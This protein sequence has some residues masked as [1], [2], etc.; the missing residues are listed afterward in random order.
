MKV[1]FNIT[2]GLLFILAGGL[3][4]SSYII[5]Y[6][7]ELNIHTNSMPQ[8]VTTRQAEQPTEDQA[9]AYPTNVSI[10]SVNLSVAVDPG[11]YDAASQT[12]TLS[13]TAAFF[14]TISTPPN[15]VSGD[16]YIYGH[17]RGN[18][19]NPLNN[20]AIGTTA[21]VETA[22]NKTYT[23]KLSAV[24]DVKPDDSSWLLGYKGKPILTLQTC[25]GFWDQY[26]RLFV[27]DYVSEV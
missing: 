23:Y 15:S 18:V 16:T 26:R 1:R 25:A 11:Y 4:G 8:I 13:D 21:A 7:R 24:H 5:N 19:F 3:L 10:P 9:T 20:A 12:W 27:F 14:A 22:D 6:V 2:I 17:N